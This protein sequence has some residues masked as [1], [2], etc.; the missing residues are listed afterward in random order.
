MSYYFIVGGL[1]LFGFIINS[2]L[3]NILWKFLSLLVFIFIVFV[4]LIV[5]KKRVF[6]IMVILFFVF[7]VFVGF[8]I[9]EMYLYFGSGGEIFGLFKSLFIWKGFIIE[10][11]MDMMV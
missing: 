10:M 11:I 7:F 5:G 6:D 8:V 1:V 9:F 4:I 3:E 2:V